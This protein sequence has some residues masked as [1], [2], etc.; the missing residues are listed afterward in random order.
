MISKL[1]DRLS[2]AHVIAISALFVAL[3]TV[4]YASVPNNSVTTKKIK[5]NAVKTKKLK[6]GAVTTPKLGAG[7]VTTPKLGAGA[8]NNSKLSNPIYWAYVETGI[9]PVLVRG[10][11]AVSAARI[12]NGNYRVNFGRDLSQC[13]YQVTP[14]DVGQNLTAHGELDNANDTQVFVSL[15]DAA[16]AVRTDGDFQVAVAC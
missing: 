2:S 8:V 15:R 13:S 14:S 7:A 11:G 16:T 10:N 9:P 6:D 5:N 1:M 3:G 4:A 12:N